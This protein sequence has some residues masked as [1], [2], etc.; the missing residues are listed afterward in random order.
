M[1]PLLA[2]SSPWT[3]HLHFSRSE[4]RHHSAGMILQPS[5]RHIRAK[6]ETQITLTEKQDE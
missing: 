3:E 4:S 5:F 1:V 6:L 2:I